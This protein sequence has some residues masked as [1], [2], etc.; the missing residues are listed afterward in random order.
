MEALPHGQNQQLVAVGADQRHLLQGVRPEFHRPVAGRQKPNSLSQD[1]RLLFEPNELVQ[2]GGV[3]YKSDSHFRTTGV[4]AGLG[5]RLSLPDPYFTL[6]TELGYT[7][8]NLRNWEMFSNFDNGN[9]NIFTLRAVF[10]RGAVNNPIYPSSGTD[11][12]LTVTLTPP[13][14]LFDPERLC[15]HAG[16][17]PRQIQMD[18]VPQMAGEGTVVPAAEHPPRNSCSW[19]GRRWD[20]SDTTT[21]PNGPRRTVRHSGRRRHDRLQHLRLRRNRPARVFGRQPR[22]HDPQDPY[23]Y[24]NVY[25][26]YTLELKGYPF[27]QTTCYPY[28][29]SVFAEAGNGYRNWQ[30][31]DPFKLH[32]SLVSASGYIPFIGM[33]GLDWGYGFDG[34]ASCLETARRKTALLDGYGFL[35]AE[36]VE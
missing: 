28:L 33:I 20:I 3:F 7:R 27:L 12:S 36:S 22:P 16:Q 18:R 29:W 26:K 5:R 9:S 31:F 1:R 11:F 25:N 13:Y 4:S 30:E 2:F 19:R 34:T 6:Y 8:Y 32:R 15:E 35:K 24:A 23:A 14:S 21:K 17:R 10:G